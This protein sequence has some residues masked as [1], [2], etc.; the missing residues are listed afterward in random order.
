M[1]SSSI[2]VYKYISIQVQVQVQVYKYNLQYAQVYYTKVL[3]EQFSHEITIAY[4]VVSNS[5]STQNWIGNSRPID[6]I[7]NRLKWFM[8][9]TPLP[10]TDKPWIAG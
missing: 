1:Q 7:I 3:D 2:Q 4:M 8:N 5:L 9:Y 6:H 10:S